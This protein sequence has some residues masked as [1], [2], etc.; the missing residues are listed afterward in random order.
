MVVVLPDD[1]P[2]AMEKPCGAELQLAELRNEAWVTLV[3]GHAAREQFDLAAARFGVKPKVRFQTES[4]DVAQ[5]L[6]GTGICVALV[7]RLALTRVPGTT[8]RPLGQPKLNR[9]LYAVTA[10]DTRS[11]PLVDTFLELLRDVSGEIATGWDET[12]C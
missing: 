6:V 9:Q 8:C 4:Y 11:T 2:L 1:H 3:S 10:T 5:A 7:S 12:P